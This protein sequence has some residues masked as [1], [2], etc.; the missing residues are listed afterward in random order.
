MKPPRNLYSRLTLITCITLI[1]G[2]IFVYAWSTLN[3]NDVGS[4]KP[5]T[6]TLMQGVI[7][8]INDLNARV[9]SFSF[10]G[11]S[12]GIGASPDGNYKLDVSGRIKAA[13]T[14][15]AWSVKN[16][17]SVGQVA[18]WTAIPGLSATFTLSRPAMVHLTSGGVQRY[19]SGSYCHVG[20]RYVVD[21]VPRGD[22]TW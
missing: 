14:A 4:G 2:Y 9:S 19:E 22:A 21:G 5:L 1:T 11:G 8:N 12:V 10:S 15:E 20:Y 18:V 7:N 16:T 17:G 13:G 3:P 6:S